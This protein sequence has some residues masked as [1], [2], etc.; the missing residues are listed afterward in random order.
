MLVDR[1]RNTF[2][3]LRGPMLAMALTALVHP[4]G[5]AVAASLILPSCATAMAR[6]GCSMAK[7]SP[8][9]LDQAGFESV[10]KRGVLKLQGMPPSP[11]LSGVDLED[12]R[13]Y[14]RM[15]ARQDA[16]GQPDQG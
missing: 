2:N 13:H 7:R 16:A 11:H 8:I 4:S 3:R 12:I 15:R 5:Q 1:I 10:V 6:P 14:L 9:I